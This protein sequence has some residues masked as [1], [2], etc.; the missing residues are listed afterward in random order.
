MGEK[1]DSPQSSALPSQETQRIGTLA[2]GNV[3]P[4]GQRA[5]QWIRKYVREARSLLGPSPDEPTLFLNMI[6]VRMKANRL[7]TQVHE[8]I[9]AAHVGKCG[10]CHLFRHTFATLLMENG[11]DVRHVQEMLGHTNMETT[12]IYTHVAIKSLKKVHSRF[13][14]AKL[15]EPLAEPEQAVNAPLVALDAQSEF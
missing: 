11:C 8:M 6:G 1:S 3:Q 10:S 5:L 14:P 4:I 7:G 2:T 12:A 9:R 13:H 15:L